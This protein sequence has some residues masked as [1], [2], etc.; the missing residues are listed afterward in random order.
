[1]PRKRHA[2]TTATPANT[3]TSYPESGTMQQSY[4]AATSNRVSVLAVFASWAARLQSCRRTIVVDP[5]AVAG[6]R[7]L[8]ILHGVGHAE[9]RTHCCYVGVSER[10]CRDG[11]R[12]IR[13]IHNGLPRRRARAMGKAAS[14]RSTV[15]L[16]A[17]PTRRAF[18]R[19]SPFKVVGVSRLAFFC[20]LRGASVVHTFFKS[21]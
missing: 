12:H 14:P 7:A 10:R 19:T 21:E 20:F 15:T 16:Q 6:V 17:P 11:C 4:S 3:M 5:V 13:M 9:L 8:R 1:M 18:A 2:T